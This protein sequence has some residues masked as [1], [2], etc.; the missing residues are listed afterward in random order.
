MKRVEKKNREVIITIFML[1]SKDIFAYFTDN[2]PWYET[3]QEHMKLKKKR[4]NIR[5]K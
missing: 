3:K 2:Q 5:K 1:A 4:K